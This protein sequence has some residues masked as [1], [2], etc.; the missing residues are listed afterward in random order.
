VRCAGPL[1]SA[2]EPVP[3][4]GEGYGNPPTARTTRNSWT[5][6][7]TTWSPP[8]VAAVPEL[9]R[10]V[11]ASRLV[12]ARRDWRAGGGV[13]RYP[14]AQG[15][16][17]ARRGGWVSRSGSA[18]SRSSRTSPRIRSRATRR[19]AARRSSRAAGPSSPRASGPGSGARPAASG[20]SSS[21]RRAKVRRRSSLVPPSR[22]AR[23]QPR[24]AY[25][26]CRPDEP[27]LLVPE[28]R[29]VAERPWRDAIENAGGTAARK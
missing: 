27:G 14:R 25:R 11:R 9:G 5:A 4:L 8:A 10:S 28:R 13:G 7:S 20:R 21:R 29:S 12:G 19:S 18:R 2:I 1:G 24:A 22:E 26:G 23:W 3:E 6:C 17:R 15:T 16:P